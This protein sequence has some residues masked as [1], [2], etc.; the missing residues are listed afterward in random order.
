M[1]YYISVHLCNI[2]GEHDIHEALHLLPGE[3]SF[4]IFS[5]MF[6]ADNR[7]IMGGWVSINVIQGQRGL[8][9][10]H[11]SESGNIHYTL[12]VIFGLVFSNV[13]T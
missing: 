10:F 3:H 4:C 2:Y 12:I 13:R 6:S 8:L 11:I 5:L 7:E 1:Y 9:S